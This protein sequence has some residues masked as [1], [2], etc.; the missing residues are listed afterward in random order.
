[1]KKFQFLESK[2]TQHTSTV[3]YEQKRKSASPC[4]IIQIE[5]TNYKEL[6]KD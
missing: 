3:I 5:K 2:F 6:K 4:N 1:V